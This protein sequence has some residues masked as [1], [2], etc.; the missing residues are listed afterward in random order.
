MSANSFMPQVWAGTLQ[1]A[2]EKLLGFNAITNRNYERDAQNA[3]SVI[4]NQVANPTINDYDPAVGVTFASAQTTS[5]TLLIDQKKDFAYTV[6]NIDAAQCRDAGE[7]MQALMQGAA[8][9]IN[10]TKDQAIAAKYSDAGIK[11][12]L[13]TAAN[14][15]GTSSNVIEITVDGGGSSVKVIDWIG[16]VA[17][18]YGESNAPQSMPR[19]LFIPFWLEQKLVM[20]KLLDIRGVS[21][22][23]TFASAQ[24]RQLYGFNIVV[25]NNVSYSGTDYRVMAG[26]TNCITFAEQIARIKAGE[27]D[28]FFENYVAGLYVYGLKTVRSD[29]LLLSYVKE[30]VEGQ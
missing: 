15:L 12:G 11:G 14:G 20:A 26:N 3:N 1:R 2:L 13:P 8:Y 19:T 25:S 16:R 4:I 7:L 27:R 5:Q 10:D 9:A 28:E 6:N 22:D 24:I 23:G 29:Q 30:G 17:R 21:N 18:R